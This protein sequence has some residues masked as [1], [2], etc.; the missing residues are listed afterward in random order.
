MT[1]HAASAIL[2]GHIKRSL[3]VT[4]V[5]PLHGGMVNTVEEWVTNGTPASVVAKISPTPEHPGLGE[6]YRMLDWYRSNT[7]FPVPR[8]YAWVTGDPAFG[9]TVLLME[10]LEGRHLGAARLTARG[11]ARVQTELA[12]HLAELHEY[13][14]P[15]YGSAFDPE[16]HRQWLDIFQRQIQREFSAVIDRLSPASRSTVGRA[17][18]RLPELMPECDRPTLVHGDLWATNIIVDDSSPTEPHIS[19]FVDGA[20]RYTDVEYELAYLRVFNTAD[21]TFF[22]AY[23]RR[24]ALREGFEERCRI[25][26]LN[27]MMLHVRVFGDEYLP[28]TERIAEQLAGM[29]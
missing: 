7:T 21:L 17:V 27:T 9:G 13:T 28:R 20:A 5:R 14:R 6:E 25:Y 29:V 3:Q 12:E 8:P 22:R 26:W 16:G 18:A 10:K 23:T 19:G 4:E 24:H 15:T 2:S 1:P 11:M